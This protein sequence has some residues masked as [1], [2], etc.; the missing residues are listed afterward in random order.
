MIGAAN[1]VTVGNPT[2][3][4]DASTRTIWLLLCSNYKDDLEWMIHAREGK[5]KTGRRVWLTKSTDYGVTW[6]KPSEITTSV[7]KI[8]R[9]F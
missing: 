6:A 1:K 2:A 7:K 3:V 9:M 4:Y 5:D 8:F